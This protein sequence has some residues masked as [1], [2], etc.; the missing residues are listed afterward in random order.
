MESHIS[1]FL[2]LPLHVQG[3]GNTHGWRPSPGGKCPPRQNKVEASKCHGKHRP[4]TGLYAA[5]REAVVQL[6]INIRW[7]EAICHPWH[8]FWGNLSEFKARIKNETLPEF[9]AN[10]VEGRD[11][12]RL[13]VRGPRPQ[14]SSPSCSPSQPLQIPDLQQE[15]LEKTCKLRFQAPQQ[16]P[17]P[18]A[19]PEL[20]FFRRP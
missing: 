20:D 9:R 11:G 13:H 18:L 8:S 2:S 16:L 1:L 3:G 5:K 6:L 12:V 14:P 4:H 10:E 19:D 15:S 7:D 17:Y